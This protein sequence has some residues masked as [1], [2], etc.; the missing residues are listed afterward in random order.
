M[1]GDSMTTA[2][3]RKTV[4]GPVTATPTTGEGTFDFV[5]HPHEV[6]RDRERILNFGND[7]PATLPL[8]YSHANTMD[9]GAEIGEAVVREVGDELRGH[10]TLDLGNAMAVAIYERLLLPAD[11]PRRL[12]EMSIAFHFDPTRTYKG[13]AG[14]R[15]IVDAILEEVSVVHAGSQRTEIA[16]VKSRG[17]APDGEQ[18]PP[19]GPDPEIARYGAIFDC[20]EFGTKRADPEAVEAFMKADREARAAEA[21]EAA[22]L[23][24]A[25]RGCDVLGGPL[26]SADDEAARDAEA[27]RTFS[28]QQ[29]AADAEREAD[30]EVRRAVDAARRA[31]HR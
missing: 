5:I 18:P 11:D 31:T 23:R 24:E 9:P 7:F 10:A 2:L 28:E 30:A 4:T 26:P 17:R 13:D 21:S 6:D 15:V 22:R 8:V 14:E 12:A 19:A 27:F 16:N 1:N 20:L 25:I 29:A 3:A